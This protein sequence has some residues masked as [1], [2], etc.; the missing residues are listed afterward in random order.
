MD[1]KDAIMKRDWSSEFITKNE[2][3]YRNVAL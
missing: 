3:R 2:E 1:S